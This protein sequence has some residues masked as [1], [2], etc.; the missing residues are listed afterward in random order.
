MR[1]NQARDERKVFEVFVHVT[2]PNIDIASIESRPDPEPDI[3]CRDLSSTTGYK[4][5]ELVELI[6]NGHAHRMGL[7]SA[8]KKLL[9]EYFVN[10]P[11][12][13]KDVFQSKFSNALLYFRFLKRST[14][15]QRRKA[16]GGIFE[17]LLTLDNGFTGTA[18]KGDPR[19]AGLLS[20]VLISRGSYSG[21]LFDMES[22]GWIGNP[23]G[24]AVTEKLHKQYIT[25][26]PM[27]LLAYIDGNPMLPDEAW[28]G[29][30][31]DIL[32]SAAKPF[33]FQRIWVLDRCDQ[34]IKFACDEMGRP[35]D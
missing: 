32:A 16:L 9:G 5:F 2:A 20:E 28:L 3:L 23:T 31:E 15:K 4:A 24:R 29:N 7:L 8:T 34:I 11:P 35:L 6:D 30:L 14:L 13:K 27:E 10:L 22:V 17:Q 21:P 12:Q 1:A 33:Q 25:K 18:F 19:F 26:H